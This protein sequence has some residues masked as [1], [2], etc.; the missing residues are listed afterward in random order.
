[1][2]FKPID[3]VPYKHDY[4]QIFRECHGASE[5][6]AFDRFRELCREDLFFLLYFGLGNT[7]LNDR[8]TTANWAVRRCQEIAEGPR[9]ATIDLWMRESFKSTLI[10]YGESIQ[11]ILR[12]PDEC[13]GIF[14]Y[15]RSL[16]K[17]ILRQIKQAFESCDLLKSWFPDILWE[18]PERESPKWSED[19]GLIV[20]RT[21]HPKESTVEAWGLVD[22]QPTGRHF[23]KRVYDDIVTKESVTTADQIDKSLEGFRLSMNLGRRGGRWRIL[24]TRYDFADLFGTLI[25]QI[26][27]GDFKAKVRIWPIRIESAIG[28]EYPLFTEEEAAEKEKLQGEYV[29][30]TQQLLSPIHPSNM[31]FPPPPPMWSSLSQLKGVESWP[32]YLLVDLAGWD[33]GGKKTKGKDDSAFI[34]VGVDPTDT[35]YVLETKVGRYDPDEIIDILYKSYQTWTWHAAH[36]EEEKLS[37]AV[38]FMLKKAEAKYGRSIKVVA[39]TTKGRSKDMRI[40]QLQAKYSAQQIV[41]HPDQKELIEQLRQFPRGGRRDAIDAL[42]YGP[43]VIKDRSSLVERLRR[44]TTPK[45]RPTFMTKRGGA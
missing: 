14:A 36:M 9:S 4:L 28:W 34:L 13:I 1:M 44:R 23:S 35:W 29:F 8:Y 39:V 40:R 3:G 20:R 33:E 12:D 21:G 31:V 30:A 27:E 37:K 32:K 38:R 10:S 45:P 2:D 15:N 7:W 41:V 11:D 25:D 5:D 24:G 18:N 6:H 17:A 26:N 19:D 42:A 22:A 16:A 43:D